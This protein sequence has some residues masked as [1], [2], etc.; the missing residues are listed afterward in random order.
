MLY[1]NLGPIFATRGIKR[2]YSFL[3]K[4]G[5]TS[6]TARTILHSQTRTFRLDH[7]EDLCRIL[8]CE[9]NDLLAWKPNQYVTYAAQ[10]PL[11]KL[12][13]SASVPTLNNTLATM[14][15]SKLKKATQDFLDLEKEQNS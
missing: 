6:H 1:L 10:N 15:F 14:P 2:P 4:S 13:V 9:P 7:I 12:R 3:V 8:V 11:E 5:F